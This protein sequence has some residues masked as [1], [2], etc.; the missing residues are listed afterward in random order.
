MGGLVVLLM[1][2]S[3]RL[4]R[5]RMLSDM[6]C[7]LYLGV[8]RRRNKERMVMYLGLSPLALRS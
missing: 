6:Q 3:L 8:T 7:L 2:L 1:M 4:L 5:G